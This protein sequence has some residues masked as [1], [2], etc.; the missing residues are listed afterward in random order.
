MH[1]KWDYKESENWNLETM[2]ELMQE[3]ES[4]EEISQEGI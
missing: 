2:D 3:L 4:K 1:L